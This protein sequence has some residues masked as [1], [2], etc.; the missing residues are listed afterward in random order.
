MELM[1]KDL[2]D[3]MEDKL[4][5]IHRGYF[6]FINNHPIK[7]S[8]FLNNN[9]KSLIERIK[10]VKLL[11]VGDVMNER[12]KKKH[13][14]LWFE[15]MQISSSFPKSWKEAW[16]KRV[17]KKANISNM[18]PIKCNMWKLP[19]NITTKEIRHRL[20]KQAFSDKLETLEHIEKRHNVVIPQDVRNPFEEIQKITKEET[21]RNVQFK[22][23]H[24]IYP[25]AKH[26]HKW[27]LVESPLCAHCNEPETLIHVIH[28]CDIAQQSITNIKALI[29]ELTGEDI[30]INKTDMLLGVND[31]FSLSNVLNCILV[32]IKRRL[33]LQRENKIPLTENDIKNLIQTQ[34]AKEKYIAIKQKRV[35]QLTK[36][37]QRLITGLAIT[38]ERLLN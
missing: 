6:D 32:L 25:T 13:P 23:L 12:Y 15:I 24:N 9:Q 1:T 5:N 38:G 27:G 21:L 31:V 30:S 2:T 26:L 4:T 7:E 37:W 36:R 33:V 29:K 11:I 19:E 34:F 22:M 20:T 18:Y 8:S 17:N 28:D 10:R 16:K 14:L 35:S 3:L